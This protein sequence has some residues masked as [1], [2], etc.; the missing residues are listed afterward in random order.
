MVGM[1]PDKSYK[2]LWL[3]YPQDQA[4]SGMNLLSLVAI[5]HTHTHIPHTHHT[6]TSRSCHFQGA[7]SQPSFTGSAATLLLSFLGFEASNSW[8]E[9]FPTES[10]KYHLSYLLLSGSNLVCLK[11]CF[12]G[13]SINSPLETRRVQTWGRIPT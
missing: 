5:P 4:S 1:L 11:L 3:H 7:V 8:A 13:K 10:R 6:H 12:S 9:Q 2:G